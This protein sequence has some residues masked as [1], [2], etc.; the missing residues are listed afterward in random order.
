MSI[1]DSIQMQE[2]DD[3]RIRKMKIKAIHQKRW[4][5][6]YS[7]ELKRQK[8]GQRQR[9][10]SEG[11][12]PCAWEVATDLETVWSLVSYKCTL[13]SRIN[14]WRKSREDMGRRRMARQ[15]LKRQ[16]AEEQ[17]RAY[18]EQMELSEFTKL[19]LL[20]AISKQNIDQQSHRLA[21]I[22]RGEGATATAVREAMNLAGINFADNQEHDHWD[23]KSGAEP[24]VEDHPVFLCELRE[25]IGKLQAGQRNADEAQEFLDVMTLRHAE[26]G[27]VGCQKRSH[28]QA[29][30]C[31]GS[32]CT[33]RKECKD[34]M[35]CPTVCAF[36]YHMDNG[37]RSGNGEDMC[38]AQFVSA[39]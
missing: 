20:N 35:N 38:M 28:C 30:G 11:C 27:C 18:E 12:S 14:S 22:A 21:N 9:R 36:C 34:G 4:K 2:K 37:F 13:D 32:V 16:A 6:H 19:A 24:G 29:S 26:E 39:G 3:E 23:D 25:T 31:K 33:C 5:L 10:F 17:V 7:R 1:A 8:E 15:A